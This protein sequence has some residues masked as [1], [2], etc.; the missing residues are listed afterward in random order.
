MDEPFQLHSG[1]SIEDLADLSSALV[2]MDPG[3][4]AFH[5]DGRNDFA[6][7]VEGS[8]GK[9]LL[10]ALLRECET[11][12]EM[13]VV[14][15]TYETLRRTPEHEELVSDVVRRLVPRFS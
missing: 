13:T 12:H 2:T 9:P 14:V 1:G 4:F 10:A 5:T 8:L 11:A 3:V 6:A 7:W 15:E